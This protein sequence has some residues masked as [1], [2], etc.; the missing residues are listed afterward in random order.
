MRLGDFPWRVV[1]TPARYAPGVSVEPARDVPGV[2]QRDLPCARCRYNLRGLDPGGR[3][4][5]CA[6]DVGYS[7]AVHVR[8]RRSEAPPPSFWFAREVVEGASASLC[9]FLLACVFGLVPPSWLAR[10]TTTRALMMSLLVVAWVMTLAAVWKLTRTDVPAG[11]E[12]SVWAWVSRGVAGAWLFGA[13]YFGVVAMDLPEFGPPLESLP[14]IGAA[15]CGVALAGLIPLRLARLFG[16]VGCR[17]PG[18][19][20]YV[21]AVITLPATL[22]SPHGFGPSSLELLVQAPLPPFTSVQLL[23]FVPRLIA[24][25]DAH[26]VLLFAAVA[27]ANA[28]LMVRLIVAY[29]PLSRPTASGLES[30]SA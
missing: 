18:G 29:A 24:A 25:R 6:L 22:L 27:L 10:H 20:A 1:R 16:R 28:A 15:W 13:F 8:R 5:E 2:L 17:G 9:A 30:E 23:A 21:L 14:L 3:C 11:E 12:P 7:I 4:P 19:V 26:E